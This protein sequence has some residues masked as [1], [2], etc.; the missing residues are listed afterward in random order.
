MNKIAI[1]DYGAGNL[2]SVSSALRRVAKEHNA[3]I[4][5]L[6]TNDATELDNASHI[7]LP[8]VGA[9]ADCINNLRGCD[10]MIAAMNEQIFTHNKPFLGICVGMQ[11]LFDYGNEYGRH[12]GLGWLKGEIMPLSASPDLR[13]PHMG[14]NELRKLRPHPLLNG[15]NDGDDVYFV[16]SYYAVC[17]NETDMLATTDYGCIIPAI[18]G[19]NNIMGTQFHPEKSHNIGAT[20]LNNFLS[21]F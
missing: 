15:V 18:I 2:F 12:A 6:I 19:K 14:W 1:I 17:E 13:V 11:M 8:G 20:I 5:I 10:G 9:F 7:I 3:E 16:H 4:E 21:L